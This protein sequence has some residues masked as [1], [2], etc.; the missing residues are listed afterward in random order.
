MYRCQDQNGTT[1]LTDNPAQL[2]HCAQ[3]ETTAVFPPAILPQPTKESNEQEN[4][5]Q[6]DVQLH[7]LQPQP[8]RQDAP[9]EIDSA[10][11][12]QKIGG[13]FVV[14]VNLNDERTAKLIVDTGAS[15]TVLSTAVCH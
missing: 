6:N 10:I 14:Q 13:S 5:K 2:T 8:S 12:L 11:P 4:P 7:S 9:Q 15:M 3:L 1:V